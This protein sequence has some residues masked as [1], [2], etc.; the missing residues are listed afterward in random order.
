M[1]LSKFYCDIVGDKQITDE[2]FLGFSR[3]DLTSLVSLQ[4]SSLQL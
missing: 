4:I 1:V 3:L 2:V